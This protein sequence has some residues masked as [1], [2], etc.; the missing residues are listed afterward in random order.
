MNKEKNL[1]KRFRTFLSSK[2]RLERAEI[3]LE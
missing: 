2:A 3:M 1:K